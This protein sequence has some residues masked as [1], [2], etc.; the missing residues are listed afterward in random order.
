MNQGK[1]KEQILRT[2]DSGKRNRGT[3]QA[4]PREVA[5]TA[6]WKLP[7]DKRVDLTP[8]NQGWE[9]RR[10]PY[11]QGTMALHPHPAPY[12]GPRVEYHLQSAGPGCSTAQR[13]CDKPWNCSGGLSSQKLAST[14]TSSPSSARPHSLSLFPAVSWESSWDFTL[15]TPS[16][17]PPGSLLLTQDRELGS[18]CKIQFFIVTQHCTFVGKLPLATSNSCPPK[19]TCLLSPPF[20]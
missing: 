5:A 19:Y 2:G 16:P 18:A 1:S 20:P 4:T 9:E 17:P 14:R 6:P 8:N 13:R 3:R 11:V 12:R 7:R 10:G 15:A